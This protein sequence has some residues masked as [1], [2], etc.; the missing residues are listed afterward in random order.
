MDGIRGTIGA[1]EL[2]RRSGKTERSGER[3]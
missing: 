1:M 3:R 2:T